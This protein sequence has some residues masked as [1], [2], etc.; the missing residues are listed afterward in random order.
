MKLTKRGE[1]V[2]AIAFVFAMVIVMGFVGWLENLGM[3]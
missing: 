2:V 1:T 3:N